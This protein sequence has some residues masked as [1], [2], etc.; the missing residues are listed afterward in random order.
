MQVMPG[1]AR[2]KSMT[3]SPLPAITPDGA[4]IGEAVRVTRFGT[5]TDGEAHCAKRTDHNEH[6]TDDGAGFGGEE[7]S[8]ARPDRHRNQPR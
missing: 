3:R 2:A 8:A 5:V 7:R 4:G 1:Y 6:D